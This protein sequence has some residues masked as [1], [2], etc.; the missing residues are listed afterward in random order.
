MWFSHQLFWNDLISAEN[1][2]IW[3]SGL[4]E[5][6][7]EGYF[8]ISSQTEGVVLPLK[9]IKRSSMLRIYYD[10]ANNDDD[11]YEAGEDMKW[12]NTCSTSRDVGAF[13][14]N[15]IAWV[16][17]REL[18]KLLIVA[19]HESHKLCKLHELNWMSCVNC[20]SWISWV[21]GINCVGRVSCIDWKSSRSCV[22]CMICVNCLSRVSCT[23]CVRC[24][25]C[26]SCNSCVSCVSC[27]S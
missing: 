20:E 11:I 1:I 22:S 14:V 13:C 23:S 9:H 25:S 2:N 4:C 3:I 8:Q 21:S 15:C 5:S 18:H 6:G 19:L 16:A 7:Y 27:V 24:I 10:R 26:V 12:K 17:R